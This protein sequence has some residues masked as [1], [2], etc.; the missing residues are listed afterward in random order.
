MRQLIADSGSTKTDWRLIENNQVVLAFR[1]S[2]LNPYQLSEKEIARLLQDELKPQLGEGEIEDVFFYGAGCGTAEKKKTVHDSL[3]FVLPKARMEVESDMLGA[4][5]AL[6]GHESG[7][8]AILGTGSNSCFYDGKN[9]IDNRPSL[10]YVLGDEG[11]GAWMGKELIRL[12]L[13]GEMNEL[14]RQNFDHRFKTDK[15]AILDSVYKQPMPNRYLASFAKFIFQNSGDEQCGA[16][17]ATNFRKF[18]E[19]HILRYANVNEQTLHVTGSVGFY[20]SNIL[21]RVAEENNIRLGRVVE[22]PVAGLVNYYCGN[23]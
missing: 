20:F 13:Y 5:R 17:I 6:C 7:I 18:F 2:G 21:R 9:I 16:I 10:G 11:S 19:Y 14:L 15:A 3:Q 1:T 12:Y 22:T 4:A 8:A 23:D